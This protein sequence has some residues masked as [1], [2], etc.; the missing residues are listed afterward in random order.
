MA[1]WGSCFVRIA[2]HDVG[3]S[4]AMA[5]ARDVSIATLSDMGFWDYVSPDFTTYRDAFRKILP[6]YIPVGDVVVSRDEL[7]TAAWANPFTI[8][9]LANVAMWA[10][11]PGGSTPPAGAEALLG[12]INGTVLQAPRQ[13]ITLGGPKMP[14]L[15]IANVYRNVV[16][17]VAGGHAI[18]NVIHVQG[19]SSGQQAACAAA[20]L[21]AWKVASGPLTY[22]S[23]LVAM[24]SVES[25]D[26]TTTNGG[27]TVVADT[28]VGG[29]S[30]PNALAPRSACAIVKLNGGTRSKS[31]RGRIYFGPLR[32]ANVGSDGATITSGD[33]TNFQTAFTN[34]ES[35]LAGAGFTLGVASRKLSAFTAAT[36][37]AVETTVATQRRRQRS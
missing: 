1:R 29:V 37:L 31:T 13:T 15:V 33:R 12:G 27:I 14:Q 11:Q 3:V 7:I 36:T 26:L 35:S 20:V 6:P 30:S 25:T 8:Q 4:A 24:V 28:T 32:S 10:L 9:G 22:L 19:T 16:S 17:M 2:R 34:F 18:E 23:S 21:A 5:T